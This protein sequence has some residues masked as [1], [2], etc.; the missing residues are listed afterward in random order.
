MP[1]TIALLLA[2]IPAI[3]MA[4]AVVREKEFGSITNLYVTPAT[5]SEF[6]LGKQVPYVAL[7]MAG[8]AVIATI[9]WLLFGV[10][11]KGSVAALA[12]GT[13]IYVYATTAYGLLI[14]AFAS[15]QIAALFGTALLT[16]IPATSLSGMM[17]PNSSLSGIGAIIGN[18][19]P[20]SYY[21]PIAVGT[22]T[23]SLGFTELT[24][25]MLI[26]ALFVPALIGLSL[27][28]LRKQEP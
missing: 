17:S 4:L 15:T 3:L 8:F 14:S 21:L 6:L 25:L 28:M 18:L 7:A 24:R 19:F 22:F 9:A 13:L 1:S 27:V 10:A 12:V 26:L 2:L 11:V 5:R 20:M 23:K 16:V